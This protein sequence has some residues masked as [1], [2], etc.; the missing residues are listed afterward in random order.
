MLPEAAREPAMRSL[1][2]K[3]RKKYP[4]HVVGIQPEILERIR[5]LDEIRR[6]HCNKLEGYARSGRKATR[7][8]EK[9]RIYY[10][11]DTSALRY[12]YVPQG[13]ITE[14]LDHIL[15]QRALDEAFLFIP[16]FCVAEMFN[17]LAR[18]HF[19]DKELNESE[20][21]YCKDAFSRDIH[22]GMLFYHYEL[23]RYHV[24]DVDHVIPFEHLFQPS[25]KGK[26]RILS[27]FDVLIVTMGM[28]LARITGGKC[29]IMTC[30]R[31]IAQ[32]A[33]VLSNLSRSTRREY[34]IPEHVCFAEAIN[35]LDK[36][37]EQMPCFEGQLLD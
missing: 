28:E 33:K 30:D 16:N 4:R 15:E 10:L 26:E 1:E 20:Y 17:T 5:A 19:R 21:R 34:S 18:L 3:L 27:T 32:I 35:V 29:H 31:R 12:L 8:P 23:N 9:G 24:L 36:E 11:L 2:E 22:N 37:P 7:A 14:R 13:D 6:I 25:Y